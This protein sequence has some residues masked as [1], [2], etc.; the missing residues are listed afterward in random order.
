MYRRTDICLTFIRIRHYYESGTRVFYSQ[1][2]TMAVLDWFILI[3]YLF[4]IIT[5]SWTIGKKQKNREDYYVGSRKMASW[6]IALSMMATQVSAISLVGAPAFVAVQQNGG[7]KWIQYEFAIPLAMIAI[8]VLLVPHFHRKKYITI[9]QLIEEQFGPST[10]TALAVIFLI[11]R[12]LGSGVAL[13]ATSIVTSVFIHIPLFETILII[14]TISIFYTTLGGIKADIYSDILQL[15]ILW[16]GT[17]IAVGY[18]L[19]LLPL[20]FIFT[21]LRDNSRMHVFEF[22]HTGL[23]DGKQFSFWAMVIGG[24]FLYLSYYGCDQSQAQR[25]LSTAT[26][27]EAQKALYLNGL[28]RFFLVLSYLTLGTMLMVF[29]ANHPEFAEMVR[30]QKSDFLVPLFLVH[31]FPTGFLGLM[32]AGFFAATMSSLDSALNSLSASTYQDILG[33][34]FP[35]WFQKMTSSE[36]IWWSRIFTIFWGIISTVFALFLMSGRETVIEMVNKIGSAF[37][38][39]VLAIFLLSIFSTHR[40]EIHAIIG[41]IIGVFSNIFLW[42]Q[43]ESVVSWL[44]WNVTGFVMTILPYLLFSAVAKG[45]IGI[46]LNRQVLRAGW[47]DGKVKQY[48]KNLIGAFVFFLILSAMIEFIF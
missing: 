4:L 37:Y 10:R 30:D 6:Q 23:G 31:Y 11:S 16:I 47:Q 27:S 7:L 14:G 36:E 1:E 17:L 33:K 25:L 43:Y 22:N 29:M 45:R 24:F 3:L 35:E 5:M 2:F 48:S 15:A 39:P 44:W 34:L 13:L 12:S 38:G 28:F 18:L 40:N 41:M 21:V 26:P 42:L 19:Y 46:Q 32:V 8:M 9:Y 20:D